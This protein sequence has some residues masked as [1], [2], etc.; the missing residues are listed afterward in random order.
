MVAI[1]H[2]ILKPLVF[3]LKMINYRLILKV[4]LI[5]IIDQGQQV[6]RSPKHVSTKVLGQD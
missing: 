2:K 4:I 1:K 5:I 3:G 6:Q